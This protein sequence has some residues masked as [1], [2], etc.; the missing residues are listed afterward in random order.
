MWKDGHS[1][2]MHLRWRVSGVVFYFFGIMLV[3]HRCERYTVRYD[4]HSHVFKSRINFG[5]NIPRL[6]IFFLNKFVYCLCCLVVNE[7]DEGSVYVKLTNTLSILKICVFFGQTARHT[8]KCTNVWLTVRKAKQLQTEEDSN[9]RK[10]CARGTTVVA[11]VPLCCVVSHNYNKKRF[12]VRYLLYCRGGCAPRH[13]F[14]ASALPTS[15]QWRNVTSSFRDG[16]NGRSYRCRCRRSRGR[17]GWW[18]RQHWLRKKKQQTETTHTINLFDQINA[19]SD[20]FFF[21]IA[22]FANKTVVQ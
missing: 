2:N 1:V 7:D 20:F 3:A 17:M 19:C 22:F 9:T 6:Y 12:R 10:K 18:R 13:P 5:S 11:D 15:Y 14:A 16:G 4:I 21:F 8:N